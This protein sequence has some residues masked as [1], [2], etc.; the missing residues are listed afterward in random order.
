MNCSLLGSNLRKPKS[1]TTITGS[2][3]ALDKAGQGRA[4]RWGAGGEGEPHA[5]VCSEGDRRCKPGG[6]A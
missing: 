6:L 1:C 5:D 4:G 3:K 2:G